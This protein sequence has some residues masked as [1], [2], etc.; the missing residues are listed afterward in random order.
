MDLYKTVGQPED[1]IGDIIYQPFINPL[2]NYN[3]LVLFQ[4]R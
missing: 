4:I 2:I 1:Q 3:L